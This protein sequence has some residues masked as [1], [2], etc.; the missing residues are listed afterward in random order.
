MKKGKWARKLTISITNDH[1]KWLIENK[2]SPSYLLRVF[3][4]S[5]IEANR[6]CM[7]GTGSVKTL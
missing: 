3:I 6:K 1:Y 5:K 7:N 4:D 2:Q